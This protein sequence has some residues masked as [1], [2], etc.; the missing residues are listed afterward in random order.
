[1]PYSLLSNR[2]FRVVRTRTPFSWTSPTSSITTWVSSSDPKVSYSGSI[3]WYF[4]SMRMMAEPFFVRDDTALLGVGEIRYLHTEHLVDLAWQGHNR[5]L[6][7]ALEFF[8]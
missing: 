4:M 6:L 8:T 5:G 2:F 7:Q 1:M 3:G